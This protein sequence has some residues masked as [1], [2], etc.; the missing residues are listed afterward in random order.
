WL[1][2]RS[3]YSGLRSS[4]DGAAALLQSQ[5]ERICQLGLGGD[6]AQ[7]NSQMN[8]GLGNLRTNTADDALSSHQS[9]RGDGFQQ[10]LRHEGIY[11]GNA[12]DIDDR[13]LGV[14]LDDGSEETFH[15]DLSARTVEGADDR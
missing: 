2:E 12:R 15:D 5:R 14:R 1:S 13:D 6:L 7:I 9:R 4:D 11:G 3:C 8:N 10:M